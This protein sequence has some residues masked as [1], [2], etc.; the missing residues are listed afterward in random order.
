[1]PGTPSSQ[2]SRDPSRE[3]SRDPS[4]TQYL[5]NQYR[6]QLPRPPMP[7]INGP[8]SSNI[9]PP[10]PR[11]SQPYNLANT[12][13]VHS[14]YTVNT[15]QNVDISTSLA[16]FVFQ[17]N[18]EIHHR[19]TIPTNQMP[20]IAK[21]LTPESEVP[22]ST[23]TIKSESAKGNQS[24]QWA[25]NPPPTN[26]PHGTTG[27]TG[28]S[29]SVDKTSQF[30]TNQAAG[31]QTS[32]RAN[33]T[34]VYDQDHS[35]LP[36]SSNVSSPTITQHSNQDSYMQD[37]KSSSVQSSKTWN[38]QAQSPIGSSENLINPQLRY[39]S[40]Q[41]I[42]SA[43]ST[44]STS[45][46]MQNF[47]NSSQQS[48]NMSIR[49]L[50]DYSQPSMSQKNLLSGQIEPTGLGNVTQG[51]NVYKNLASQGKYPQQDI[52][53]TTIPP[54]RTTASFPGVNQLY[55][56]SPPSRMLPPPGHQM[57]NFQEYNNYI[58]ILELI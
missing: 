43:T 18:Q 20:P 42:F 28:I 19:S 9:L 31:S 6:P 45:S 52:V 33:Q 49:N 7:P 8:Q 13:G 27:I 30:S 24:Y 12:Y 2:S 37:S 53:N 41:N 40:Q 5:H 10:S 57:V 39:G 16:G 38:I 36:S 58:R 44:S 25:T 11:T 32:F 34:L 15:H 21:N 4:P 54:P 23:D 50:Q 56:R 46:S 47:F 1:M 3:T 29:S 35:I 22:M 17:P 51:P 48:Y 26:I 14:Q 55:T